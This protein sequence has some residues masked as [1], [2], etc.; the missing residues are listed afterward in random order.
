MITQVIINHIL[1][2]HLET[3]VGLSKFLEKTPF[4]IENYKRGRYEMNPTK[5]LQLCREYG[6]NIND[7]QD[8]D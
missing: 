2:N 5:L 6:L 1:D 4:C 8:N 3:K 7:F